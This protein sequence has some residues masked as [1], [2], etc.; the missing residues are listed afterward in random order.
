MIRADTMAMANDLDRQADRLLPD[1]E[2][3]A[4][5]MDAQSFFRNLSE[6]VVI[7]RKGRV[8]ARSALTFA[9]EY[10]TPPDYALAQ[11]GQGDVVL[12]MNEEQGP[13]ACACE[14]QK[15]GKHISVCRPDG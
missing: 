13:R 3:F 8:L 12:M 6:A 15:Y 10:E 7:N 2:V 9:L 5:A 1:P 14:A 4:K 11:A